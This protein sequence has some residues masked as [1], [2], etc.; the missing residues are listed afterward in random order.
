MPAGCPTRL[1]YQRYTQEVVV[2][3]RREHEIIGGFAGPAASMALSPVRRR[4]RRFYSSRPALAGRAAGSYVGG[5]IGGRLADMIDVPTSPRHRGVGHAVVPQFGLLG[6]AMNLL[7]EW[8]DG[9][10]DVA[11]DIAD[12]RRRSTS[13]FWSF[14]AALGEL[15]CG[16]IA[17]VPVGCVGGHVSHLFADATTPDGLRLLHSG[18]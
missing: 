15:A 2:P 6:L 4:R 10:L 5:R 16:F 18:M 13:P 12:Y 7:L 1:L 14:L 8:R 3:N 9:W 11:D 17:E